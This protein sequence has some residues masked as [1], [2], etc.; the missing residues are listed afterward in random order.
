MIRDEVLRISKCASF[1]GISKVDITLILINYCIEHGKDA[2]QAQLFVTYLLETPFAMDYFKF[3]LEFWEKK[4]NINKL[5]SQ[6][7]IGEVEGSR[8]LLLIY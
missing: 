2:S 4:F 3:A 7:Q 5:Y 1:R 6:P 8:K